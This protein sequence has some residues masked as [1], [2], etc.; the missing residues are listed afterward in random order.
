MAT[1]TVT[2]LDAARREIKTAIRLWFADEDPVAIHLLAYSS[3]EI[4]HRLYRDRGHSDLLFDAKNI[5]EQYRDRFS[6]A[7]KKAANFFKHAKQG[8]EDKPDATIEF[9]PKLNEIFLYLSVYGLRKMGEPPTFEDFAL[10]AYIAT[11]NPGWIPEAA[12][13]KHFD[14]K[15]LKA[16]LGLKGVPK[17]EFFQA[18]KDGVDRLGKTTTLPFLD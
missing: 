15:S 9:D 14:D 3:H 18:L 10:Y 6:I 7:L 11:Q 17:K 2:K 4:V 12:L 13:K 8:K 16:F 1:I 5:K